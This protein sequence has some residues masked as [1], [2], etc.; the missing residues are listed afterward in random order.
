M[1]TTAQ[2]RKYLFLYLNTG[3]GHIT[4]AKVLRNAMLEKDPDA[5]IELLN[6]FDK[7]NIL[8][9]VAFVRGYRTSCNYF[10]GAFSLT[11]DLGK[12][13]W[14]QTFANLFLKPHTTMYLEKKIEQ[15]G[16]TDV[17]SFHFALNPS[18]VSALRRIHLR[19]GKKINFKCI[20]T[21]P[22]T[23]PRV[24][25]YQRDID[26]Y[27]FSERAKEKA[28]NFCGVPEQN[29]TVV[30]F[31]MNNK[32]R[33]PASAE[34]IA[35]LK[36]KHGFEENKKI[37]LI[38]GGGEGLPGA[39]TIV[40]QLALHRVPFTIAVVC[41]RDKVTYHSIEL[42]K[43]ANP[44]LDLHLFGFVNFMDELIKIC[45]CAVIKAGPATMMEVL[46]S[47]KPVIICRYIHNQELGN[48]QFA[49]DNRVGWFIRQP[50]AIC[51]K[52]ENLFADESSFN[53]TKCELDKLNIDTNVSK[54]ACMLLS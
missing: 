51:R 25:F 30:P 41:G 8:G 38:A 48:V 31:L 28:V 36:K 13:R 35:E 14:F 40:N 12:N 37:V 15:S 26:Y 2:K 23:V 34:Q 10:P 19:T 44:K 16:A 6:G 20:V 5:D 52:I 27:V 54:I 1:Q 24:W 43:I 17:I 50:K 9:Q 11:Y 22:F 21:D 29:I 46:A 39:L 33:I 42:L 3:S 32:F 49:I 18:A 47:K 7:Y 4:A 45:D 53:T